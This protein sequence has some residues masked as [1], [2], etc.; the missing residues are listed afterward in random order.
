V[1]NNRFSGT[2]ADKGIAW[3]GQG[4]E[5]IVLENNDTAP[6]PSS[7]VKTAPKITTQPQSL[8]KEEGEQAVFSVVAVGTRPFSYRWYVNGNLISNKTE[9]TYTTGTLTLSNNGDKY[10]CIV[11]NSIG[12]D[13]SEVATL[14]VT[15]GDRSV[16]LSTDKAVTFSYQENDGN[17]AAS[18][19]V[20][21]I[22]NDEEVRWS[23]GAMPQWVEV[24]LGR[25]YLITKTEL[26]CLQGRAYHFKV[27]IR[28]DGDSLMIVNRLDNKQPGTPESP[29]TDK[30]EGV[31]GRYVR[32]T[33]VGA[34]TYSGTWASILEF[35]VLGDPGVIPEKGQAAYPWPIDGDDAVPLGSVLSWVADSAAI[36]HNVYFGTS[37][38]PAF[39][40][41][42][43]DTVFVPDTL[44]GNTKYYWR[45]DEVSAEDTTEGMLWSFTTLDPTSIGNEK[46]GN[47]PDKFFV[48]QN[49]PN[50]FNPV[51][52]IEY[53]LPK[54]AHVK[55]NVYDIRGRLVKTILDETQSAG[56]RE[57]IF[58]GGNLSSGIYFY[59]LQAGDF[60]EIKRMLLIK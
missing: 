22:D 5:G 58:D 46:N 19:I 56:Y 33:V 38:P 40:G 13:T 49:Y 59:H 17:R 60:S 28:D 47:I 27:E 20:D 14:S 31:V 18:N 21:G 41:N 43:T 50:P 24:D 7:A 29:I 8:A 25:K 32:L 39:A 16:V 10:Y 53:A 9:S 3:W 42:Q 52:K 12:K 34:E 26:V 44:L 51:T 35:S 1:K 57:V 2:T 30:F 4:Q 37:N 6:S 45:V 36:S 15:K 48:G 55:L 54:T 11:S 23:A